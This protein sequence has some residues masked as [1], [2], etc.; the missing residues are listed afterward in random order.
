MELQGSNN[1]AKKATK[2]MNSPQKTQEYMKGISLLYLIY[3]RK[4]K[5]G[6]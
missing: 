5:N 3:R 1:K 2:S 4:G 6:I